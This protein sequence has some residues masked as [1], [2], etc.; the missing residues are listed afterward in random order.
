MAN[1]Q[2]VHALDR[3]HGADVV[4]GQPMAGMQGHA[5]LAN[6]SPG[7]L[8]FIE[9]FHLPGAAACQGILSGVKFHG[10]HLQRGGHVKLPQIGI[11]EETNGDACVFESADDF[12]RFFSLADDIQAAFGRD[13]F[14]A[15]RHEGHLIRPYLAGDRQHARLAGHFQV[16]LDGH[17]LAEDLQ[18]AIL[19]VAA[20][21]AEVNR[22]AVVPP[23]S[24]IAAAQTGSGSKVRRAW[25]T[26]A[27]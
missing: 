5:G 1:V 9:L 19:N 12:D 10:R 16:E 26:V 3:S 15:F 2:F 21:L 11:E 7:L 25:R 14:T 6:E 17:G 13:L 20:I 4:I 18:I 24:D 22:D 27:T 23:N 8:E